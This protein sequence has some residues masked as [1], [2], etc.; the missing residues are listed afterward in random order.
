LNANG[1]INGHPVNVT[2]RDNR[3]DPA[4]AAADAQA[5][6]DGDVL[7]A[8]LFSASN[9]VPGFAQAITRSNLPTVNASWCYGPSVPGGGPKVAENYFCAGFSPLANVLTFVEVFDKFAKM[10]GPNPRAA[11][12]GTDAPGNVVAF[13]KMFIPM[14]EQRGWAKGA[15]LSATPFSTT[16]YSPAARAIIDSGAKAA[17]VYC[18]ADCSLQYIRALRA[19]GFKGPITAV[20]ASSEPEFRAFKDPELYLVVNNSLLAENKPVHKKIADAAKRFNARATAGDLL[21]GWFVGMVIEKGLKACGF[22][23]SREKLTQIFN[24]NFSLDD[25]DAVDLIGGKIAWSSSVHHLKTKA[26]RIVH[27]N[28]D[29][30][31][32]VN[33]GDPVVV[34]DPG[35]VFP[36]F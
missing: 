25:Q 19:A 4:V 17:I 32:F 15:Y 10:V 5:F 1:G 2:F 24:A 26:F 36:K 21:D 30:Q 6:I 16:D 29:K 11:Y 9:T 31:Q 13:T 23:C 22:P 27:W 3:G 7:T 20:L 34:E 18:P 12:A 28:N 8:S 35:L 14:V 33:F